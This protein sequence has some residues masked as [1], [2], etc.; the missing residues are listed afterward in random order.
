[1]FNS[2]TLRGAAVCLGNGRVQRFSLLY[3]RSPLNWEEA[4]KYADHI[5]KHGIIQFL[6]IYNKVKDRQRDVL[7]WG[8]EVE[9]MLVELDDN[10][11]KVRLVLNGG[12]VLETLQEQGEKINPK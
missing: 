9:Y 2:V 7:K 8:D 5:R 4:R 1:M 11:E 12:D 10:D 6:N 3:R